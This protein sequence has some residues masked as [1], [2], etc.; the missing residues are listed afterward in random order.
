[1]TPIGVHT[2]AHATLLG[3]SDIQSAVAAILGPY[4]PIGA[5]HW[6]HHSS[7]DFGGQAKY[8]P[9]KKTTFNI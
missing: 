6:C 7:R 5:P 4:H 8:P 9:E 2:T 1:M 3:H